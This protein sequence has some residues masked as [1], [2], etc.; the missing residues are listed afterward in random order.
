MENV[1][2]RGISKDLENFQETLEKGVLLVGGEVVDNNSIDPDDDTPVAIAIVV[3]V[4]GHGPHVGAISAVQGHVDEALEVA[5]EILE[6][7][8]MD[9]NPDY[10]KE[11]EAEH[12]DRASEIF[13]ETFDGVMWELPA[14]D[15]IAAIKGTAAEKHIDVVEYEDDEVAEQPKGGRVSEPN[16]ARDI[17]EGLGPYLKH[18]GHDAPRESARIARMIAG[19]RGNADRAD[20]VLKEVDRLVDGNGVEPIRDENVNDRYYGDVVALY[21]NMGDTY[22]STLLY[23][24]QNHE[25]HVTSW[26]DWYEKYEA[27]QEEDDEGED[28][29]DEEDEEEEDE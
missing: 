6:D 27:E 10:F 17:L 3:N 24:T 14:K 2:P 16:D 19:V 28:E 1:M 23:D 20:A 22:E 12:G 9:H 29:D 26:G 15:F 21:V 11:L 5:H 13:T 4:Q 8:E 18:E 7:W 25:F